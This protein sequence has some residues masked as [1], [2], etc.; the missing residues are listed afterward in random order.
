MRTMSAEFLDV[1]AA[2][3]PLLVRQASRFAVEQDKPREYSLVTKVPSPFPQHK[4]QHM[5][6]GAVKIGKGYVSYHLMPLYMNA[7]LAT[8]ISP[9]LK[10]R[11]QGKSCFNFKTV[12]AETVLVQLQKLTEAAADQWASQGFLGST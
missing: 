4:G 10:T 1:F 5:A 3:K 8:R 9:E 12:P 11:M 7:P 6:F 2:L